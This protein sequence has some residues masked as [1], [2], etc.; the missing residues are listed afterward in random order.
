[1]L[2]VQCNNRTIRSLTNGGKKKEGKRND[3]SL[4]SEVNEFEIVALRNNLDSFERSAIYFL[5]QDLIII[6]YRIYKREYTLSVGVRGAHAP[7]PCSLLPPPLRSKTTDCARLRNRNSR[8]ALSMRNCKLTET[9]FRDASDA[10]VWLIVKKEEKE[11]VMKEK[12]LMKQNACYNTRECEWYNV[13]S[14]F[15]VRFSKARINIVD[16]CCRRSYL[17]CTFKND[18]ISF[19][20]QLFIT[21]S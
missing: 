6:W 20:D 1:M 4:I 13:N 16:C 3:I 15:V 9:I 18:R 11:K 7:L 2:I 12:K 21:L 17:W 10:R 14:I 19:R 8:V 5:R